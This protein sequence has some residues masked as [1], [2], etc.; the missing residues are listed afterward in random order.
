MTQHLV[1]CLARPKIISCHASCLM[2]S[3]T[4]LTSLGQLGG[5][6]FQ[7]FIFQNNQLFSILISSN[8]KKVVAI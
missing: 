2:G 8:K 7:K 3:T 1:S 5:D 4:Y 6:R